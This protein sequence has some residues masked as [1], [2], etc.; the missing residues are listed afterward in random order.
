MATFFYTQ[1]MWWLFIV[2]AI[3]AAIA[4]FTIG[5]WPEKYRDYSIFLLVWP[6]AIPLWLIVLYVK[7]LKGDYGEIIGDWAG[8]AIMPIIV[9]IL[10]LLAN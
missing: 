6:I 3:G 5:F 7:A 10:L 2:W 8:L 9:G 4:N 1:S